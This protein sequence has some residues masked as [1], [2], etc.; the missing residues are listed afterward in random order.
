M[1]YSLVIEERKSTR[2]FKKKNVSADIYEA[3]KA[4][5]NNQCMRL[6][7]EIE[8]ECFIAGDDSKEALE[9]AA[10]YKEFLVGAPSYIVILSQPHEKAV[11]NAG[12]ITEDLS[13]MLN[14]MGL[15]CCFVTFTD[16]N[17]IKSALGINSD[18]EAAAI[19]A[20]GYGERMRKKM[21][22]NVLTMS[23]ITTEEKQQYFAPKKSMSD[24]VYLD[25]FGNTDG[26]SEKIDFYG[27]SLWEPLL[28]ASNSP[29]YMNKQPYA[30][31]ISN[32][33]IV[34]VSLPDE[35]TGKIDAKLN[36]GVVM[37]HF[38]AVARSYR[39]DAFWDLEQTDISGLPEGA[40]VEGSI[41]I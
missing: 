22:F 38:A 4:F 19:L 12:Y 8:T 17:A 32:N 5:H 40:A 25:S 7:P 37:Q 15:G 1:D 6:V 24:L 30:F 28:A 10:G 41:I 3:I 11:V 31:V 35:H 18:K 14:D 36:I 34:L 16:G 2:A 33:R 21:H 26:V 39:G 23:K 29:S 20:F 9:G 27:D 13:L